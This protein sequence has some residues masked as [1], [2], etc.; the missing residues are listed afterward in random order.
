MLVTYSMCNGGSS[1]EVTNEAFSFTATSK[2]I[3][4]LRMGSSFRYYKFITIAP[5]VYLVLFM[6]LCSVCTCIVCR[7]N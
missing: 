1:L 3:D 4:I 2:T 6:Y 5:V 7:V